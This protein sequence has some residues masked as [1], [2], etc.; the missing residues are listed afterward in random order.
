[1][2][3][4]KLCRLGSLR[5]QLLTAYVAGMLLTT[6][7]IG[8]PLLIL[9][10]WQPDVMIQGRLHDA[11]QKLA[12][13][14]Q[15]DASGKPTGIR[16]QPEWQWLYDALPGEVDL[17]LVDSA[18]RPAPAVP[19]DD[20]RHLLPASLVLDPALAVVHL[21][22]GGQAVHVVTVPVPQ[23]ASGYSMQI[24]TS[25]RFADLVRLV[26][27][28]VQPIMILIVVLA[29]PVIG[30]LMRLT[31]RRLL[32]PLG[33]ASEAAAKIDLHNL[34]ARIATDS[35]P[36]ELAPLIDAFNL[37]LERLEKGY[38][39]QQE[40]LATAAHE[41][42][43]PLALVRGQIE[44]NGT[45]DRATLL[46]D[47][48]GMA[49]QVHQLL[50]LAEV[51]EAQ[52]YVIGPTDVSAVAIDVIDFLSRLAEDSKVQ[53]DLD[54]PPSAVEWQADQS[55]LFTLLKNLVENA[56][57]HSPEGSVVTVALEPRCISVRDEGTGI[58]DEHLPHIFKR[59]WRGP[60]RDQH[61]DGGAGLGLSICQEIAAAHG[62]QLQPSAAQPGTVFRL[63]L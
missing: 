25:D 59:F 10:A 57:Q 52:N 51:S 44:L 63:S 27:L 40:F 20:R 61:G 46:K 55:A 1:M 53:L 4:L 36:S 15:F 24:A 50:H 62:W 7:L 45:A 35:V 28:P 38:R 19:D 17:R 30:I 22:L 5:A 6:A 18:G 16:L 54:L 41:L 60:G 49:R 48:D 31:L 37:A 56:I 58:R 34:T 2:R 3:W 23:S 12:R 9:F 11:A 26:R 14:Q 13:L 33:A 42:K 43:T 21:Q 8:V 29:L 32:L 47:I 39:V